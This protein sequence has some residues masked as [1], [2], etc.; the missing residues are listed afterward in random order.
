MSNIT[1]TDPTCIVGIGASAGG[2]HA[3]EM[4][5]DRLPV[6][7]GMAFVVI[8]HLS[9]H[10]KSLMDDLLGRHTSMPVGVATHDLLVEANRIYLIPPNTQMA[11]K[12]RRLHLSERND[13]A[14]IDL[15]IDVFLNSLADSAKSNAIA[16][17]MSGTGTDGSRGVK[18]VRSEGGLVLVQS[19]DS[20]QFDGMPRSAL[21]TGTCDFSSDPAQLADLL[22]ELAKDPVDI[23]TKL[24]TATADEISTRKFLTIFEQLQRQFEIDFSRYKTATVSRRVQRR[25]DFLKIKDVDEYSALV[26]RNVNEL[27]L[28]Y[29]DL[30][31]GVTEFFRDPEYFEYLGSEILPELLRDSRESDGLRLWS[32]GCATGE[33]AYSLAITALEAAKTVGFNRRITV[34]ATDVHRASLDVA[35]LGAYEESRLSNVSPERL[36]RYFKNVGD[37][38]Y[39]V[40]A[41]LRKTVVFAPHNLANDAPISKIDLISCRNLLIYF[42]PELQRRVI[43]T[44]HFALRQRG[45][46][47]LG[48]SE[49]PG[50]PWIFIRNRRSTPQ[51]F[52]KIGRKISRLAPLRK[53]ARSPAIRRSAPYPPAVAPLPSTANYS[54]I[55]TP[56]SLASRPESSSTK[57]ARSSTTVET[58]R[59]FSPSPA[60]RPRKDLSELLEGNL[61]VALAAAIP[62]AP[63]RAESPCS[64]TAFLFQQD[65]EELLADLVIDPIW[66]PRTRTTHFHI[67][68]PHIRSAVSA[69]LVEA[70]QAQF[71][72]AEQRE[73]VI[74]ISATNC[75]WPKSICKR[76]SCNSRPTMRSYNR[77]TKNF[78][79]VMR[80]YKAPTKSSILSMRNSTPSTV[81]LRPRMPRSPRSIST[82]KAS[83]P[84][85]KLASFSSTRTSV[86]A[87]STTSSRSA[88]NSCPRISGRPSITLL[89]NSKT[90]A[91]SLKMPA[92]S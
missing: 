21:A 74:S 39:R 20:A 43:S 27:H 68:F 31:I 42:Q 14:L 65:G 18:A 60:S 80:S 66:D 84:V 19:P 28:L 5:F 46:L 52:S 71:D 41:N 61:Q 54:T 26:S 92:S 85:S 88:S 69:D 35:G 77:P 4:F 82:S 15:P 3:L 2:L 62:G 89:T 59:N 75:A 73:V 56:S 11:L 37:D 53:T 48:P 8:Q 64:S 78:S 81:K 86:F 70:E 91:A 25:M 50:E 49:A 13:S 40:D 9:P 23:R 76:Q 1:Y 17:I 51:D 57:I 55:T 30:L 67:H 45:I 33:E 87:S 47:F 83:S 32:A 12:G 34:F 7:T 22:G 58:S 6:D 44:F 38:K 63:A 90:A 29:H 79:P 24:S 36:I 16:I 72:S 10:F